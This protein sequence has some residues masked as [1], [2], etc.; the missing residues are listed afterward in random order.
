V[1]REKLAIQSFLKFY[2]YINPVVNILPP[3]PSFFTKGEPELKIVVF[4]IAL[5]FLIYVF[6][7]AI[8][9]FDLLN[10]KVDLK[11]RIARFIG[12]LLPFLVFLYLLLG[13]FF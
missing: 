13:W 8:K 4:L 3:G 10:P 12:L 7:K 11:T 5:G 2:F 1:I 6:I 9:E